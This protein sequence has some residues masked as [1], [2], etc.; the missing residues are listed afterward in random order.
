M[1]RRIAAALVMCLAAASHAHA[2]D[3]FVGG[4]GDPYAT[5]GA[6]LGAAVDGDVVIVRAGTYRESGLTTRAA[7]VT[8]RADAGAEVVVTD[9]GA[10]VFDV[11]HPRTTIEGLIFDAQFGGRGIRIDDGANQTTL[12]NIEV[13]NAGN[14][15][16]DAGETGPVDHDRHNHA[17][18]VGAAPDIGAYE[19]CDGGC[20]PA[21]DGGVPPGRDAGPGPDGG[22][23]T[24]AGASPRDGGPPRADGG[25]TAGGGDGCGCRSVGGTPG[26]APLVSSLAVAR[27]LRSR[28]R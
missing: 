24:D 28:R 16:I 11:Q 27:L 1:T 26:G 14:H 25:P 7:G 18:P 17:R 9:G 5:I 2:E 20:V 23:T 22:D 19:H 15:C 8:I 3:R 13:R 12:R 10:R 6:A 4:G 21:L